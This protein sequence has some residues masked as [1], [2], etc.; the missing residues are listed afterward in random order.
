M[1]KV[2]DTYLSNIKKGDILMYRA[3]S[4]LWPDWDVLGGIITAF[5]GNDGQDRDDDGKQDKGYSTGDYTHGAFVVE[6]PDPEAIVADLGNDLF[7]IMETTK[8]TIIN[9][10]PN[11][12]YEE[13]SIYE[14]LD[15]NSG[16][17]THATWPCVKQDIIDWENSSM[18]VWRIK[19]ATPEI[20]EGILKIVD[21][22]LACGKIPAYGYDIAE[23]IT[24]GHIRLPSAKI[25]SQFI[26]DPIFYASLL[27]GK[28]IP[29]CLTPD[30]EQNRDM[31][32]TPNDII[33]SGE[34]M[35]VR[36]QGLKKVE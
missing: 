12:W 30:V 8:Q 36:Y 5:E 20:I 34:I 18:E 22:M 17:R 7:K 29:I 2:K 31:Q 23:F 3:G 10:K 33:N 25:C 26:A 35:R 16:V 1:P 19:R 15:S 21:N 28:G 32:I 13:K 27:L 11:K 4:L 24:F 6:T 9:E 14:R